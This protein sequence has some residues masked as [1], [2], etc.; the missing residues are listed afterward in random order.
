MKDAEVP[1]VRID[2]ISSM[3]SRM[4]EKVIYIHWNRWLEH[5]QVAVLY[6]T[7]GMESL[8]FFFF[9]NNKRYFNYLIIFFVDK[10]LILSNT[11]SFF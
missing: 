7:L 6:R 10:M 8:I 11:S 5:Q 1:P 4:S 2:P 9:L 3:Y